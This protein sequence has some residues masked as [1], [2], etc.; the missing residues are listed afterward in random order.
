[1]VEYQGAS[2]NSINQARFGIP[3]PKTSSDTRTNNCEFHEGRALQTPEI[4]GTILSHEF[5]DR[6]G[7]TISRVLVDS[8]RNGGHCSYQP[9]R[10]S[11]NPNELGFTDAL[12]D[13]YG[14]FGWIFQQEDTRQTPATCQRESFRGRF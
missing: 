13:R 5:E 6:L 9:P 10:H 11:D 8:V 2:A 4:S 14:F 12:D 1:M 3:Q 7:V